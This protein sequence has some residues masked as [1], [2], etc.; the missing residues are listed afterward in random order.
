MGFLVPQHLGDLHAYETALLALLAF[1][2]F[3]VLAVVV[4]M[5]RRRDAAP[6][7]EGT[8]SAATGGTD[9]ATE[10]TADRGSEPHE[11]RL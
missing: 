8:S 11:R 6:Q 3:V 1:G 2:P 5:L 10:P 9:A 7:G 4:V